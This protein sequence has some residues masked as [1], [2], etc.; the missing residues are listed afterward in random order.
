[1][2]EQML[3]RQSANWGL[4][5]GLDG[6]GPA[7]RF[8]HSGSVGG[9][10]CNLESFAETGQGAVV[11]TSG[12]QGWR[13]AREILWSIAREYQWPNYPYRPE[14]KAVAKVD[15][16]T[17]AQYAGRYQLDPAIAPGITI[18]ISAE[19]GRLFAQT[20]NEPGRNELFPLSETKFFALED[21]DR[22]SVV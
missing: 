3:T 12:S 2:T 4:G 20:A 19:R 17:L 1:M 22:K 10:E 16:P 15:A 8:F 5:L 14:V 13:L 6:D 11:M 9:F 7:A 18:I 21:A